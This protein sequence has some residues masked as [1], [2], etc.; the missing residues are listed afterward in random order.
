MAYDG[1]YAPNK[2]CSCLRCKL[3]GSMGAAVLL[4][5]GG[6]FLLRNLSYGILHYSPLLLIVIGLMLF[7]QR[8]ASLE[9]HVQ[10][11]GYPPL[12]GIVSTP[13]AATSAGGNPNPNPGSGAENV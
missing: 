10:P 2:S 7:G 11:N 4:T 1:G 8:S 3:H 6:I 12:P 13:P 5:V 9:G